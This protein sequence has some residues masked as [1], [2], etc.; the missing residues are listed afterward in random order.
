MRALWFSEWGDLEERRTPVWKALLAVDDDPDSAAV[1]LG[2]AIEQLDSM[3]RPFP[4]DYFLTGLLAQRLGEDETAV[5]LLGEIQECPLDVTSLDVGWGLSTLARLYRARSLEALG[6]R[7]EA[8]LDYAAV[9]RSWAA[10]G[11]EVAG[12]VAE[13]KAAAGLAGP[14]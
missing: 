13:A 8:V 10:G 5:R 4:T 12:F 9:A 3:H 11:P 14:E 2:D 1:W 7:D 6:L